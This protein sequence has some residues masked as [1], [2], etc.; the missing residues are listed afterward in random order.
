MLN[1]YRNNVYS[2]NGE[3]GITEEVFRRLGIDSGWICSFGE[4]NGVWLSNS[5]YWWK[6]HAPKFQAVLIEPGPSYSDLLI[7]TKGYNVFT[8]NEFV[9]HP[10]RSLDEILADTPI[11]KDFELLSI[12]TDSNDYAIWESLSNYIPRV[13][14]IEINS[15]LG[16]T[17]YSISSNPNEGSSG[18]AMVALGKRKGYELV[19]HCGNLIFVRADLYEKIGIQDNSL[20]TLWNW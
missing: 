2:Q 1:Q 15:G 5:A 18:A 20:Q 11:P 16:S 12:D 17:H 4:N 13:V 7:N 14:I 6:D 10:G 9:G 19:A 3:D 8:F